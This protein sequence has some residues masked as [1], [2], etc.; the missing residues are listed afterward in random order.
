MSQEEC[1]EFHLSSE[2]WGGGFG[3]D[4]SETPFVS[5]L[6]SLAPFAFIAAAE[7]HVASNKKNDESNNERESRI[8]R[9]EVAR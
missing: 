9:V 8:E 5:P 4:Y 1:C 7:A 6:S 3:L 2:T